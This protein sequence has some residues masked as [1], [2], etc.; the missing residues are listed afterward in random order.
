MPDYKIIDEPDEQLLLAEAIDRV[1]DKARGEPR[2]LAMLTELIEHEERAV[3]TGIDDLY[4][5]LVPWMTY[6]EGLT[7]YESKIKGLAD[8]LN[9]ELI[10][11]L[12]DLMRFV[13]DHEEA[14]LTKTT[15]KINSL[16]KR[17]LDKLND[18]I[19]EADIRKLE[20]ILKNFL[21]ED[22]LNKKYVSDFV[23]RLEVPDEFRRLVGQ[24]VE[25]L[26]KYVDVLSDRDILVHLKPIFEID[27]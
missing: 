20:P 12:E 22:V 6:F 8:N 10:R 14:A 4:R 27:R 3:K 9:K 7:R 5:N 21:D 13:Y 11:N 15:G 24:S 19:N 26:R 23:E 17:M 18:F 25:Q 2:V 16:F 1:L